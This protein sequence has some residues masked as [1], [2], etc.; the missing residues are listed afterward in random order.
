MLFEHKVLLLSIT[1]LCPLANG[2]SEFEMSDPPTFNLRSAVGEQLAAGS[3]WI[4]IDPSEEYI[5]SS[6]LLGSEKYVFEKEVPTVGSMF[7]FPLEDKTK[8]EFPAVEEIIGVL[9]LTF[10]KTS[11]TM[12]LA[13]KTAGE[14]IVKSPSTMYTPGEAKVEPE[15][16]PGVMVVNGISLCLTL[17]L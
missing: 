8:R 5:P 6:L 1:P 10:P 13:L 11:I 9:I 16:V 3:C 2:L 17:A 14:L 4:L 12:C 7:M 15:Y